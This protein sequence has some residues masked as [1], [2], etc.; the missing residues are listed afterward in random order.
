MRP[1]NRIDSAS[2]LLPAARADRLLI[3]LRQTLCLE[4]LLKIDDDVLCYAVGGPGPE[5][6]CRRMLF[7]PQTHACGI[8]TFNALNFVRSNN[9]ES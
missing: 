4:C 1:L 2:C 3:K 5:V 6:V 8:V 7:N 9:L